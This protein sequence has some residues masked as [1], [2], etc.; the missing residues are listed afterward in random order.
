LVRKHIVL[1]IY[2]LL[3]GRLGV[4]AG[5]NRILVLHDPDSGKRRSYLITPWEFE[6]G[7]YFISGTGEAGWVRALRATG[8]AQLKLGRRAAEVRVVE[9]DDEAKL[10]I[11]RGYPK[12]RLGVESDDDL[13]DLAPQYPV[14]RVES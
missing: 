8:K 3:V 10:P 7:R 14:F 5:G 4:P 13:R 2:M 9:L 1:P 11:L 12:A 6:G